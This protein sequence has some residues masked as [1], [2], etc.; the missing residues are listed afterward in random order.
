MNLRRMTKYF[1]A[2]FFGVAKRKS[3]QVAAGGK[4]KF[5]KPKFEFVELTEWQEV[6]LPRLN[7]IKVGPYWEYKSTG[8]FGSGLNIYLKQGEQRFENQ[9][10]IKEVVLIPSYRDHNS[11][12]R[13]VHDFTEGK[14][15]NIDYTRISG[16]AYFQI[17]LPKE[18]PEA[19]IEL[20]PRAGTIEV[21]GGS[22]IVGGSRSVIDERETSFTNFN[23]RVNDRVL[24]RWNRW[25]NW[26]LFATGLGLMPFAPWLVLLL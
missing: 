9:K 6:A 7:E 15:I 10:L 5:Y 16:E 12:L 13:H 19:K 20:N 8:L 21:G 11:S 14:Q 24:P 3:H 4:V 23:T 25:L 2:K 26:L 17:T 1:K 18:V 22:Y